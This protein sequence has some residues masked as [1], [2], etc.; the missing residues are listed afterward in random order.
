VATPAT[1]RSRGNVGWEGSGM[2]DLA[3]TRSD[4]VHVSSEP[5]TAL[6]APARAPGGRVGMVFAGATAVAAVHFVDAAV[7]E[8]WHG[9][10]VSRGLPAALVAIAFAGFAVVLWPRLPRGPRALV[11]FVAG[12]ITL[13]V[14]ALSVWH[15]SAGDVEGG[16]WSGLLLVPAGIAMV[17]C[18]IAS[19]RGGPRRGR[20][21]RWARR[22]AGAVAVALSLLWVVMPV[23]VALFATGKPRAA[24]PAGAL[25]IPH[26][27]VSFRSADGLRLSGW[28]VPSRNRA[29]IVLVHG[30]G[31]SRVGAVVQARMLAR[32]GYGVL[33]YDE[34]GRGESEGA[35]DSIGWTWDDDVAGALAWLHHR[36]DVDGDKIGGLGLST[37]AEALVQ[38]AAQ[39]TDLHAV[40]ADGVEARN[41]AEAARVS[42]PSD[43]PYWVALYAANR[44][45]SGAAPAP[46]LGDLVAE[47]HAPTLLIAAGQGQEARFG[48][49]YAQR[50]HGRAR[51]WQVPDAGH[52]RAAHV[53]PRAYDARVSGFFDRALHPRLAAAGQT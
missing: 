21:Q 42:D 23:G 43:L 27:N 33:L 8:R 39:R 2:L 48:H 26:A 29:A 50:S 31:G 40:V 20:V 14:A 6:R 41:T 19:L 46:D 47:L 45:L 44:V 12:L 11:A 4:T 24:V 37:G 18:A 35:P 9:A 3:A 15:V 5:R 10:H 52:T 28:Y 22:A 1:T 7:A 30:G 36:R 51:L 32:H 13:V 53:H 34:R 16:A 17:A 25:G 38:A 49:I